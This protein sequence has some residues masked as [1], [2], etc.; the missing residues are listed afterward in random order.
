[1]TCALCGDPIVDQAFACEQCG[2]EYCLKCATKI[3]VSKVCD[4][5]G[6]TKDMP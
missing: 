4:I 1:M 3:F 2:D 6:A 5:C